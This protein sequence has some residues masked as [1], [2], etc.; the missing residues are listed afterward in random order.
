MANALEHLKEFFGYRVEAYNADGERQ[1]VEPFGNY[2]PYTGS[3]Y[4]PEQQVEDNRIALDV[5]NK[6]L[7]GI[8]I[9]ARLA[10]YSV[11]EWA[12]YSGDRSI[13]NQDGKL[14]ARYLRKEGSTERNG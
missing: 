9:G 2:L 3:Q 4:T 10:G 13:Y 14:V 5:A 6:F 1:W 12:P 11:L 8:S 7:H